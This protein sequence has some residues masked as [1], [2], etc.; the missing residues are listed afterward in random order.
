MLRQKKRSQKQL[1][2]LAQGREKRCHFESEEMNISTPESD[3]EIFNI[4]LE[5]IIEKGLQFDV[6][7]EW[8]GV[9]ARLPSIKGNFGLGKSI[10]I[11]NTTTVTYGPYRV[12]ESGRFLNVGFISR[13][14]QYRVAGIAALLWGSWP[15][16]RSGRRIRDKYPCKIP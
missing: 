1:D 11:S 6:D 7:V 8:K 9:E 13:D 5:F 10:R 14:R 15:S 12:P 3:A 16:R 2:S 4:D